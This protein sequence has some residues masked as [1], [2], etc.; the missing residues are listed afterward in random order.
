MTGS[1]T[2]GN[3]TIGGASGTTAG[4][5]VASND[6]LYVNRKANTSL[7]FQ[8]G[9]T[10]HARFDTSGNLIPASGNTSTIGTQARPWTAMYATTF[11][12][13]ATSADQ[14][15]YSLNFS[16]DGTAACE[17]DGSA[18]TGTYADADGNTAIDITPQLINA[19]D[20]DGT[21]TMTGTLKIDDVDG[22]KVNSHNKDLKIWEVVGNAGSWNSQFGFYDL[23]KGTGSGNDN[24]LELYADNQSGTHVKVRTIKQDGTVNWHTVNTF[25]QTIVGN[26]DTADKVNHSL[27]ISFDSIS[28]F[29][30]D[31]SELTGVY[32]DENGN[33]L[34]DI[35][36]EAIN[37]VRR[38]GDTI[39]GPLTINGVTTVNNDM[40][41]DS[42]TVGDLLVNGGTRFVGDV[43]AGNVTASQFTGPLAGNATSADVVNHSLKISYNGTEQ[44]SFNGAELL[45]A[46]GG[47]TNGNT[48]IDINP[49]AILAAPAI[50]GVYYGVCNTAKD[51][52]QKEVTLTNGTGFQLVEGAI[53]MVKFVNG[54]ASASAADPMTLNV[55]NTGAK[56]M[57]CYN[58]TLM[59]NGINTSG[60]QPNAVVQFVYDGTAWYRVYWNN[61]E[62]TV[63]SAFCSTASTTAAKTA[64]NET[65]FKLEANSLIPIMMYYENT[66][67][68]PITLNIR[69]TGAKPIYINGEPSSATNYTLPVGKYIIFYDGTN[70]HFRTDGYIPHVNGISKQQ[71]GNSNIKGSSN[72]RLYFLLGDYT[73][74][75]G[76]YPSEFYNKTIYY[77]SFFKIYGLSSNPLYNQNHMQ[78]EFNTWVGIKIDSTGASSL[79]ISGGAW[80]QVP[81]TFGS[82]STIY[83][84]SD[85]NVA[86]EKKHIQ[87]YVTSS[88]TNDYSYEVELV[89]VQRL[90]ID[91]SNSIV[92]SHQS[93][94]TTSYNNPGYENCVFMF[95]TGTQTNQ[96]ILNSSTATAI[97]NYACASQAS[98]A[99]RIYAYT[100]PSTGT[101]NYYLEGR[102]STTSGA[103]SYLYNNTATYIKGNGLYSTGTTTVSDLFGTENHTYGATLPASPTTGQLFFQIDAGSSSGSSGSSLSIAQKTT[104]TMYVLGYDGS[105]NTKA[106]YNSHVYVDCSNGVLRGAAWNDYAEGRK[107]NIEEQDIQKPGCCVKENGDGTLS[108]TT[109]R[110]ERGC[111]IISDTYG[112]IIGQDCNHKTPIAVSGRVLAY[113]Y[114]SI[115]EF[116]NHIGYPVCSGPNGTVSIMT[117]MEEHDYP[118]RIIGTISEIPD[119]DIW[120]QN[121]V[122]VDGRVWIRIK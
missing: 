13:N 116:K 68:G 102:A 22:I 34:L 6:T 4:K 29:E 67:A 110:L 3:I 26:I 72:D 23:Y 37:A 1:L 7:I 45:P 86:A 35:T 78:G 103:F 105:D 98:D 83:M 91:N 41:I 73:V 49:E 8:L 11:Y 70:Y 42:A 109:K 2:V 57:Y 30:Y 21:S 90:I 17:Y 24:S 94:H 52:K 5:T 77:K 9:G 111:E 122:Y 15:N 74:P 118:S 64:T 65:L 97:S 25:D 88:S 106:Y 71:Y 104:G 85:T 69:N 38:N 56:T 63:A 20:I 48:V 27:N 108:L 36:P 44:C 58:T 107:Q 80:S 31:G 79:S 92:E 89:E 10:E 46:N 39:P 99:Y 51:T 76:T 19:V 95:T 60:W 18:M 114:E 121:N 53:V 33:S 120:G 12:G 40:Y 82:T 32:A 117:D 66:Y 75:S 61:T 81:T 96:A 14:L 28:L 54:A 87:Y 115:E 119:Y 47:D 101:T 100:I 62:Y 112:M 93:L 43:N 50:N 84:S 55:N 16:F 113:P 59:S